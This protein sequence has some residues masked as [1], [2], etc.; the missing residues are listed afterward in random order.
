MASKRGVVAAG[1]LTL[2]SVSE[3]R[4][5]F[6]SHFIPCHI[7]DVTEVVVI[8]AHEALFEVKAKQ[9]LG[10][11]ESTCHR[12]FQVV[13]AAKDVEWLGN[14]S[15][16]K[17]RESSSWTYGPDVGHVFLRRIG[18]PCKVGMVANVGHESFDVE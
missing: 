9:V 8:H 7:K 4:R 18:H 15:L 14:V 6:K 17:V 10:S 5:Q 2:G 3:A 12:S 16:E 1:N 11:V 13:E